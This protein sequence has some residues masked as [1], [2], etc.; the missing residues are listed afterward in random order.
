M[1]KHLLGMVLS[2]LGTSAHAEFSDEVVETCQSHVEYYSDLPD[3][4][5]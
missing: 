5:R 4:L 2:L 3:C 1:K